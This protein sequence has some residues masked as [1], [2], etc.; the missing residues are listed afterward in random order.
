[1]RLIVFSNSFFQESISATWRGKK[2]GWIE[3][4][5]NEK[6]N[7]R[8]FWSKSEGKNFPTK[9]VWIECKNGYIIWKHIVINCLGLKKDKFDPKIDSD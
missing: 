5:K 9:R 6:W 1:M 2:R 4:G 3:I 7:G 8:R